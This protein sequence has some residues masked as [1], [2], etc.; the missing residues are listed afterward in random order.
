MTE[1]ITFYETSNGQAN[2]YN[3]LTQ[4]YKIMSMRDVYK[5]KKHYHM[6][7]GY[8]GTKDGLYEFTTDFAKWVDKL[9]N[10]DIF[11]FDYLKYKSHESACVETFKKLCNGKFEEMEDI[12]SVE[13]EWIESCN[14][15]SLRYC[16]QGKYD[17]YG[18]DFSSQYPSILAS[19][20]FNI[21]TCR[22][23]VQTLKDIDYKS[24]EVGYYTVLISSNDERFNKV[25]NYSKKHV[26]THTSVIYA[27]QCRDTHGYDVNIELVQK[28]DNCYIYGKNKKD[29]ITKGSILFGKWFKYLSELKE[30]F[31]DN[32][33]VK[34]M[35]SALWGRLAQHNRIFKTDDE[36]EEGDLDVVMEY[37]PNHDYYI[38]NVT[39]NRKGEDVN[40]LVSCKR[41]YYLNIARIKPFLLAKSR[42]MI[43]YKAI[44]YIDDVIRIHTDNVTFNKEH[45]DILYATKTFK[46]TKEAKTT[47]LIEWRRCDCYKNYTNTKYMTKNFKDDVLDDEEND[48]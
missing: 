8:E 44:Q 12:D 41:P 46:L 13:Y 34:Y 5:L 9:K 40:E 39:Q 16:K 6:L 2:T 38:R 10:N 21:P 4:E 18:Y 20:G 47:G 43:G 1:Y 30:K 48:D 32:K 45:D 15:A 27:L 29:N 36:I 17:S 3:Y 28:E 35:T 33:L 14:N 23:K 22:G 7:A 31:P 19:E 37:N 42:V 11:K 24:I 26:Y 25:F